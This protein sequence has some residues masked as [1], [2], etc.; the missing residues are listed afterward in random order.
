MQFN[1]IPGLKELKDQLIAMAKRG[2]VPHAMLLSGY[3]GSPNLAT[4]L[5]FSTYLNC[6]N[7][8]TEDSCGQCPSCT[9]ALKYIHPDIHYVFP[10][11]STA[12]IAAKDAKS[13][14]FLKAWRGFLVNNP[15]GSIQEW[16]E[17]YGGADK[18]AF[19]SV[20]ES[21]EIIRDLTLKSF[22]GKYKIVI[23]WLPE[24]MRA[25]GANALLKFLEEPPENTLIFMVTDQEDRLLTTITSRTQRI[26][27]RKFT[28]QE[29]KEHLGKMNTVDSERIS[30]IAHL[31]DGDIRLAEKLAGEIEDDTH[32]W[33]RD[34]MRLCYTKSFG[35]LVDLSEQ[36]H[37]MNK[38]TRKSVLQYAINVLRESLVESEV[39]E[40]ARVDGHEQTFIKNFSKVLE[41]ETI[42]KIYDILNKS[43]YFLERNASAKMVFL[44]L[45]IKIS[46]QLNLNNKTTL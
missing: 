5:A 40:L 11:S 41:V 13:K 31:A 2:Q 1:Q 24:L 30:Q 4:S 18:Q 43:I 14:M 21:R 27:V 39:S 22:E 38:V 12:N 37:G 26:G 33:V 32:G 36:F 28:D 45:S 10:V 42:S 9:K 34:W 20:E 7:Q 16:T 35:D 23:V 3:S 6:E 29:V 44:S 17:T 25:E 46:E 8:G 19:I 15:F